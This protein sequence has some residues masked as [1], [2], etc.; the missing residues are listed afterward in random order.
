MKKA[1]KM[2]NT[3]V[4][5]VS[6]QLKHLRPKA[7]ISGAVLFLAGFLLFMGVLAFLM[8][9][10][11]LPKLREEADPYRSFIVFMC[12]SVMTLFVPLGFLLGCCTIPR[13]GPLLIGVF[14]TASLVLVG[15]WYSFVGA[16]LLQMTADNVWELRSRAYGL[17]CFSL[18]FPA[19]I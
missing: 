7:A 18:G 19:R 4:R 8:F 5:N 13:A 12:F 9:A 15:W 10:I 1:P 2:P 6:D 16:D 3:L 14:A 11:E 17:N